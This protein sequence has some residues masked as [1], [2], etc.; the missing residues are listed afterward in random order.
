MVTR[1]VSKDNCNTVLAVELARRGLL[2][3]P[4]PEPALQQARARWRLELRPCYF[5]LWTTSF[6]FEAAS[7]A[8]SSLFRIAA[9]FSEG[10][11][12][13]ASWPSPSPSAPSPNACPR[14]SCPRYIDRA[15]HLPSKITQT[16]G[17]RVLWWTL[18]AGGEGHQLRLSEFDNAISDAPYFTRYGHIATGDVDALHFVQV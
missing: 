4:G 12:S 8:C 9:A 1:V 11:G 2:P 5:A 15:P 6:C 10:S 16:N 13:W 7:R 14:P 17:A 18:I 3:L